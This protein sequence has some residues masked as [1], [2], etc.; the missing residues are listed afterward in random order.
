M[1]HALTASEPVALRVLSR[2]ENGGGRIEIPILRAGRLDLERT[3]GGGEGFLTFEIEAFDDMIR[4]FALWPG[5]VPVNVNPHKDFADTAGAAPGFIESLRHDGQD[6]Y[7]EIDLGPALFFEVVE[8][9]AW[10]GFSVD[11]H[12]NPSLA[13]AKLKKW[14]VVGGVFT[15]RPASDVHFKVAAGSELDSD[16][17]AALT[18][19][20]RR[21]PREEWP[22]MDKLETA[23]A[24]LKAANEKTAKL[25]GTVAS[26][27]TE[28]DTAK[29]KALTAT[30]KVAGLETTVGTLQTDFAALAQKNAV[31][32]AAA[33]KAGLAALASK[34]IKAGKLPP[35][36]FEGH[37]ENPVEFLAKRGLSLV[38]LESL[39]DSIEARPVDE[40]LRSAGSP[41]GTGTDP[42]A[43]LDAAASAISAEKGVTYQA[44]LTL[45]RKANPDLVEAVKRAPAIE[46]RNATN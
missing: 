17:E 13:S 9:G 4:N 1:R 33:T 32:E 10:R 11:A 25:E 18:V 29:S 5:P 37:D 6:L 43:K 8:Q 44:A 22:D 34:A 14:A 20:L 27:T 7:A 36:Y 35:S 31:S 19:E 26:L 21:S 45:A 16:D 40:P 38:A 24:D 41:S 3:A 23:L 42:I 46:F 39:I 15:N 28:R 12:F 2:N 30:E